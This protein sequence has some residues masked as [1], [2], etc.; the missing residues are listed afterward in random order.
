ME[1]QVPE[2]FTAML[3]EAVGDA[4]AATLSRALVTEAPSLSVRVNPAKGGCVPAGAVVVPWEP[5]GFYLSERPLFAADP[6][7]HRGEYYVQ[8]AS[9]MAVGTLT[10]Y[11]ADKYFAPDDT[12]NYLDACAAPGGKTIGAA[13]ALGERAFIVA[14]EA[15]RRRAAILAENMA[16]YGAP[17]TA[18]LCGPAQRLGALADT[19]DIIAAD[20]PCSG[21]GMMRKEAEAVAQ[22]SP[23]LV[24]SCAALQKDIVAGLWPAL[25]PGGIFIYSTCTFNRREDEDTVRYMTDTLGAEIIDINVS[26]FPGALKGE[27][28]LRFLPGAVRGEGLYMAALRK[29]D[30]AA[31]RRHSRAPRLAA[32]LPGMADFARRTVNMPDRYAVSG[33]NLIPLRH[34]DIAARL[35]AVR[36]AVRTGLPLG[37][38]KGRD[39]APSHELAMSTVLRPES[40]PLIDLPYHA[41]MSYLRGEAIESIPDGTPKG[42]IS[43]AWHGRP[44]GF[45]KNIGRRANNLYP[46]AL[47]LRLQANQLPDTPPEI[48]I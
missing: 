33:N 7:W 13:D 20:A 15:D 31:G 16:R 48:L 40:Y 12:I 14:N 46:D 8:D 5:L 43:P 11:L 18:V 44:L 2:Q 45:A 27:C 29:P 47:R 28:G 26:L 10:R 35:A 30:D 25:R 41:A 24:D 37:E 17:N 6:S 34:S 4:A 32:A 42:Y 36:G 39:I 19:F 1:R 22:W 3:R 9:S 38:P 21:E 23:A